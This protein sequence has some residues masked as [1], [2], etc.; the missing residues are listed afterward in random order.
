MYEFVFQTSGRKEYKDIT[1]FFWRGKVICLTN[2]RELVRPSISANC[3]D[4]KDLSGN[5]ASINVLT[6]Q[7]ISP[8]HK[9]VCVYHIVQVCAQELG[10]LSP[11]CFVTFE[12]QSFVCM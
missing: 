2:L 5:L 7:Q 12:S 8:H 10:R 4:P 3:W 1:I 11:S 6:V 9:F